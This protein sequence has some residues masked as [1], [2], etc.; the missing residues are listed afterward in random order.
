[1]VEQNL[2]LD[3][4]LKV[5]D[6]VMSIYTFSAVIMLYCQ[7]CLHWMPDSKYTRP[8]N[9]FHS[10]ALIGYT[11]VYIHDIINAFCD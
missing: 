7:S 11:F 2:V 3:F 5:M 4:M 1:M 9:I 6:Q 10:S 8:M